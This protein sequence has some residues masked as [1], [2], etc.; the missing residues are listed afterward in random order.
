M[1]KGLTTE[2]HGLTEADLDLWRCLERRTEDAVVLTLEEAEGLHRLIQRLNGD[3]IRLRACLG[4]TAEDVVDLKY[5]GEKIA[6][7]QFF[8]NC[9]S[10]NRKRLLEL[11][12]DVPGCLAGELRRAV[13]PLYLE[14]GRQKFRSIT[15]TRDGAK[16]HFAGQLESELIDE[17]S[18]I[19]HAAPTV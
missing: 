1:E 13:L 17:A 9:D 6:L 15:L 10:G 7:L 3:T 2:V 18:E 5:K 12:D 16:C 8:R 19:D 14:M 4:A 11:F